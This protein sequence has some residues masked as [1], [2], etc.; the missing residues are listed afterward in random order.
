VCHWKVI[1]IEIYLV[2]PSWVPRALCVHM[3]GDWTFCVFVWRI[4]ERTL[5]TS[6]WKFK[7]E[8]VG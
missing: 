3:Y 8:E 4:V 1:E 7:V 5:D 2:F 6:C